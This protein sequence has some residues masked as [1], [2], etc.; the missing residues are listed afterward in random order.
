MRIGVLAP[1][2]PPVIG[3]V[4]TYAIETAEELARLGHEVTVAAPCDAVAEGRTF[5]LL[6]CLQHR[7]YADAPRLAALEV[8]VWHGMNAGCAWLVRYGR[9]VT[10]TVHGNDFL[11][12]YSPFARLDLKARLRLPWGSRVDNIL[13]RRLARR[14]LRLDLPRVAHVFT[15][16]DYTRHR[17]TAMF[18]S[19]SAHTTVAGVGVAHGL[20]EAPLAPRR[21]GPVRFFTAARLDEPRKNIALLLEALHALPADA[22]FECCIAG[23]GTNLRALEQRAQELGLAARI[24]FAGRLTSS[25]LAKHLRDADLFVL[26]P[27]ESVDSFE[28]FGLVYLEANACGVPVLAA[29]T[30]GVTEAVREGI[31]GFFVAEL[32]AKAI[33]AALGKFLRGEVRFDAQRCRDHAAQ[34]TWRGVAQHMSA[35]Y[36]GLAA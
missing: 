34:F 1:E 36:A 19:C 14:R 27:G 16:S 7:I 21:P 10:V 17:L 29:R 12:A 5:R 20:R 11:A 24:R 2:F 30:G 15:N 23:D 31:S 3:G 32:S 9:P 26:T 33:A 18:P 8:D 35:V 6:P 4:Q 25:E 13:A 22:A 28:G